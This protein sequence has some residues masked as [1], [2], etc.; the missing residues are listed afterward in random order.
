[1]HRPP[2]ERCVLRTFSSHGRLGAV[3]PLQLSL[4]KHVRTTQCSCTSRRHPTAGGRL[5]FALQGVCVHRSALLRKALASMCTTPEPSHHPSR[6]HAYR[7]PLPHA[8]CSPRH[9]PSVRSDKPPR[10]P[11]F[12]PLPLV[13]GSSAHHLPSS[14]CR[15][16]STFMTQS[17]CRSCQSHLLVVRAAAHRS[18]AAVATA[19][20]MSQCST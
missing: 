10:F 16:W 17:Y 20:S 1:V 11:C 3:S 18:R 2:A 12:W 9:R 7:R 13:A 19:S 8:F 6:E 14:L 15:S 4:D 5:C